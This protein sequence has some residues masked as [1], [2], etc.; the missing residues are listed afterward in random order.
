[1]RV[2]AIVAA[3]FIW[4]SLSAQ[5]Y[6][7]KVLINKGRNEIRSGNQWLP[8]KVGATLNSADELKVS[9]NGYLGLVHVTGKPLEVKSP[10]QHKVADLAGQVSGGSSILNK[11]TDFILSVAEN[12]G[13]SLNATGAVHRGPNEIKV[14]LPNPKQAIVF[15][16]RIS[17]AWAKAPKTDTYIVRLNS[18]FGDELDRFEVRD[19][20]L[21]LNLATDKLMNEDNILVEVSSKDQKDVASESFMLKKLSSADKARISSSL[22]HIASQTSEQTALNNLFLASFFE[23]NK[24]L[25]DAATAYQEAIRLAPNVPYFQQAFNDFLSRNGLK[26]Q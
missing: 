20:T 23:D 8:I 17:I 19:T 9:P 7:F 10:G 5:E 11:Y 21:E 12:K 15:N 2:T 16:D 13:N 25:I 14:F 24:L 3:M 18:M 4:G 1:M 6:A 22:S 26:T